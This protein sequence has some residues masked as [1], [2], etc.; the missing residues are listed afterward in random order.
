MDDAVLAVLREEAERE[1]EARRVEA[2]RA[3]ARKAE[4]EDQMQTQP[5]LGGLEAPPPP[6]AAEPM[7]ATQRRLAM[8]R[9]EDPDA[10]EAVPARTPTRRDLLPDVE[11]LSSTLNPADAAEA[12]AAVDA[13]PDLT[14]GHGFRNGFIAVM[15]LL[16][17]AAGLY[18]FAPSLA[19]AVPSLAEPLASYVATIDG[20]RLWLDGMMDSATQALNGTG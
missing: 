7:S 4:A 8:L 2:R 3:D 13:L 5:A 12:D 14:R 18:I 16:G 15:L 1:A 20:L 17:L 11:E 9:G 10:P 6:P 19:R